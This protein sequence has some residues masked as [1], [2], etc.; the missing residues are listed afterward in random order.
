MAAS[1]GVK[2]RFLRYRVSPG[3]QSLVGLVDEGRTTVTA[4]LNQSTG[5]PY[6]ELY[7]VLEDHPELPPDFKFELLAESK[8]HLSEVE[9][10][11]P[12]T[13]RD[14][15]CIGKNC[16]PLLSKGSLS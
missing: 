15:I 1:A 11:A 3:T 14:I 4:I 6:S 9:K 13:G 5:S 7:D 10:L 8:Q 2:H 12:L 16:M